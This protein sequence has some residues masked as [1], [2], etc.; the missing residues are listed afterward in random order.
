M[1]IKAKIELINR[2][3]ELWSHGEVSAIASIYAPDFVAHMPKGW[4][5]HEYRGHAGVSEAIARIRTAFADWTENVEDIIVE[6]DKV[7][8][9]YSS[10]GLHVGTF[11]GIAPRGRSIRLD[12]ISIYRL[13]DGLVAEQWR[14]VDDISLALQLR[15]A[16]R[17]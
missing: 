6:A 14:L 12:E 9:R 5:Q 17:P 13:E 8:T 1:T 7:V 15:R 10:T 11:V 2:L 3:H 16:G 4:L